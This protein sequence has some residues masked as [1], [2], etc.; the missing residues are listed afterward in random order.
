M[1]GTLDPLADKASGGK[2]QPYADRLRLDLTNRILSGAL[3]P[4]TRLDEQ[5]LAAEYGVSRTPVREAMRQLAATGL[6]EARPHRG[7]VVATVTRQQ[8]SEMIETLAELEAACAGLAAE[9]MSEAARHDL[10]SAHSAMADTADIGQYHR[11]NLDFHARIYDGCRNTF[12]ADSTRDLRNRVSILTQFQF[13]S[14]GR[15]AAS[16]AEHA[17]VVAAIVDGDSERARSAMRAHMQS[18]NRAF[19]DLVAHGR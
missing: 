16:H 13:Q 12:L 7:V 8:L 1:S 10:A 19:V 2:R 11:M 5:S 14:F 17:E 4:G 9:R 18:T 6:V 3:L 15:V